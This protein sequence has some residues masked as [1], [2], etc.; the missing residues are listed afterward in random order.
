MFACECGGTF[1]LAGER[2]S[3]PRMVCPRCDRQVEIV[4]GIPRFCARENY[5]RSF[6]YQWE[7]HRSTQIDSKN[8]Y[9]FS[10]E[11]LWKITGWPS[12]L[13]GETVV[14]AGCGAGRFTEVLLAAGARVVAF[15]FSAAIKVNVENNGAR[16][17]LVAFQGSIYDMPLAR[18]A[19]PKVLCL[20]VL[21]HTPDPAGAFR[22]LAELVQPGGEL[23][24]DVYKRSWQTWFNTKYWYRPILKRL[25]NQRLYRL[26]R[27]VVPILLPLQDRLRSIIG[28]KLAFACVP[29]SPADL[30]GLSPTDRTLWS[31]LDT[32]DMYSPMYDNPQTMETVERWYAGAGFEQIKVGPGPNGVIARGRRR[33]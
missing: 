1:R 9:S 4:G 10:A 23:V 33:R 7:I 18:G 30:P 5:A 15:D 28:A 31:V 29:V 22:R 27:S 32:F 26:T 6:G 8:G 13:T 14:E 17:D 3:S 2:G 20:D 21:Q 25:S 11:R 24:I 12:D 19:W 16:G